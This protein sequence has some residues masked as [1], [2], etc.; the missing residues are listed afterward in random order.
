MSDKHSTYKVGDDGLIRDLS[1]KNELISWED[2][3]ITWNVSQYNWE[4]IQFIYDIFGRGPYQKQKLKDLYDNL[5]DDKRY[6]VIKLICKVKGI[7][8]RMDKV[9]NLDAKVTTDDI[10]LILDEALKQEKSVI[11]ENVN[12]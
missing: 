12:G 3:E 10:Q 2:A 9:K 1:R 11:V 5:E 8:Y 7:E 4:E 6:K